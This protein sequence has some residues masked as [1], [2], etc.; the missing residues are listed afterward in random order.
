MTSSRLL[1]LPQPAVS[2]HLGV[3][4]KVGLVTMEKNGQH[5]FYALNPL[6]L[7]PIHDW[8][9][10]FEHFWTNH[11][12]AIRKAAERKAAERNLPPPDTN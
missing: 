8:L 1:G 2:K 10:M 3:L 7:K 11:L 5:R 9:S 6:Q 12:D 4:R